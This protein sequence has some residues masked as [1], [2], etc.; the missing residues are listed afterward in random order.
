[1]VVVAT[2][3]VLVGVLVAAVRLERVLVLVSS[4][5]R[6][7]AVLRVR[8]VLVLVEGLPAPHIPR[9]SLQHFLLSVKQHTQFG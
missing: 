1:M 2:S 9:S 8:A 7:E 6:L 5:K 3:S 4:A